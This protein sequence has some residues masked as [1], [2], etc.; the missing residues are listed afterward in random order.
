MSGMW[1][2]LGW[3]VI[4]YKCTFHPSNNK[5]WPRINLWL[6]H[7]KWLGLTWFGIYKSNCDIKLTKTVNSKLYT[8]SRF[9][10]VGWMRA[11]YICNNSMC[12]VKKVTKNNRHV[13]L[14]AWTIY[15]EYRHCEYNCKGQCKCSKW[16]RICNLNSYKVC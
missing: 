4:A 16:N 12:V 6:I 13:L 11:T 2:G 7:F 8:T 14:R 10:Y 9:F 3:V 5:T 1:R 15:L